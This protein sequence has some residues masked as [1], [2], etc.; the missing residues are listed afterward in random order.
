[1]TDKIVR[2]VSRAVPETVDEELRE[3]RGVCMT[4]D[5]DS[6]GTILL[7]SGASWRD[8]VPL[9]LDHDSTKPVGSV[10][11]EKKE[12]RVEFVATIAKPEAPASLVERCEVAWH[13]VKSGLIRGVS[14]G[15]IIAKGGVKMIAGIPTITKCT[16]YELSLTSTPSN[17][18]ARI[19]ATRSMGD[20]VEISGEIS[21]EELASM[22]TV[23]ID[24]KES[25]TDNIYTVPTNSGNTHMSRFAARSAELTSARKAKL[26][27]MTELQE[28]A[29]SE[30]RS[31]TEIEGA[32]YDTLTRDVEVLDREIARVEALVKREAET[33]KPI[34]TDP[35]AVANRSTV[36]HTGTNAAPFKGRLTD[37]ALVAVARAQKKKTSI[38][39]ELRA[40][41]LGGQAAHL[42]TRA[43]AAV[44]DTTVAADL[45]D[46][47]PNKELL[48]TIM[49]KSVLFNVGFRSAPFGKKFVEMV[50]LPTADAVSELGV[51]RLSSVSF[52]SKTVEPAKIVAGV[53]VSEE[54]LEDSDPAIESV[55]S[56]PL[57]QV[58]S[59]KA[60]A[61]FF[62]PA[63]AGGGVND[64][65]RSPWY[66][67]TPVTGSNNPRVDLSAL[68]SEMEDQF[69]GGE[70]YVFFL[71]PN[72]ARKLA[73]LETDL[74]I[75][76]FKG[77]DD[78]GMG[79]INGRPIIHVPFLDTLTDTTSGGGKDVTILAA[80]KD[81]IR[82]GYAPKNRGL[83]VRTFDQGV[84]D[85]DDGN[86]SPTTINLIQQNAVL[87]LAELRTNWIVARN[88]R[89]VCW[90]TGTDWTF[91]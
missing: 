30:G 66:G 25:K 71:G 34:D 69:P 72:V 56:D 11:F 27:R 62:N 20:H 35:T 32:E 88:N 76:L 77:L 80:H 38:E 57:T 29:A 3:I 24:K 23:T 53:V 1:M 58:T 78:E 14:V 73:R 15:A 61:L 79:T 49:E 91:N 83:S 16:I 42:A 21:A 8:E 9:L 75:R 89:G 59:L 63:N 28:L 4:A 13:S 45:V 17:P 31:L 40:M 18:G 64:A 43:A 55:I 86:G 51:K 54:T 67:V 41:G 5:Q 50:G 87:F 19:F 70:G 33:A 36:V 12:G 68:E 65:P 44:V 60:D 46:G 84:V 48:E 2:Y 26:D 74:G 47:N 22:S 10:R 85:L 52:D 39:A 7:P 82:L 37:T 81:S 6:H 90:L